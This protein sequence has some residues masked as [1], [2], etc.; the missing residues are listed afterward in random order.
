LSNLS[1]MRYRRNRVDI[2]RFA[3]ILLLGVLLISGAACGDGTPPNPPPTHATPTAS[4]TATSTTASESTSTPSPTSTWSLDIVDYVEIGRIKYKGDIPFTEADEYVSIRNVGDVPVNLEGWVLKNITAG[5][6]NFSFPWYVLYPDTS[7]RVYTDEY[8][9]DWGGFEFNSK[10]P[11]W[12]NTYPDT[13]ALYDSRG[14]LIF[15]KSYV[16]E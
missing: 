3:A 14:N 15:E 9:R 2:A 12:N 10:V 16:G 1:H 8:H 13:A 6:P 5:Y 11:V 4:P 7:C